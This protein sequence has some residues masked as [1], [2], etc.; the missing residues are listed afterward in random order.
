MIKTNRNEIFFD[1]DKN[2]KPKKC[3]AGQ[4]YYFFAPNGDAYV[5]QA[6]FL[7][8][9]SKLHKK[10]KAKKSEFFLG[11]LFDGTFKPKKMNV[12][13]YPCSEYCDLVWAKP[14]VFKRHE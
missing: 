11:N 3:L 12:C 7:H 9:N 1:F 5:C 2:P 14:K 6:G 8:V 13:T 10:W 4:K